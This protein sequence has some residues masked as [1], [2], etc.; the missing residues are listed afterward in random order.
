MQMTSREF[1]Q[2]FKKGIIPI[3]HKENRERRISNTLNEARIT[4]ITKPGKNIYKKRKY[5]IPH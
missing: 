4:L 2:T 1:C 5:S 3:L